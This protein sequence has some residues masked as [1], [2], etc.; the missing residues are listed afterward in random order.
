MP[1]SRGS[2][3]AKE[4]CSASADIKRSIHDNNDRRY[5]A[6]YS[7]RDPLRGASAAALGRVWCEAN[8]QAYS[9]LKRTIVSD[10][11][12]G[13]GGD[14][15]PRV[16]SFMRYSGSV[17]FCDNLRQ[18]AGMAHGVCQRLKQELPRFITD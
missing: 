3:I 2:R 13:N 17:V 18:A 6:R 9:R 11:M 15:Y 14:L 4:R 16:F 8:P 7:D 10:C 1:M 5:H 12:E